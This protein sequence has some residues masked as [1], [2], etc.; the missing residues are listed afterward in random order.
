[1]QE[2]AKPLGIAVAIGSD[3]DVNKAREGARTLAEYVGFSR[4]E[5]VLIS[6]VA[7]ELARAV[8][9]LV[10]PGR[11]EMNVVREAGRAGVVLAAHFN[12]A[13]TSK[14]KLGRLNRLLRGM[15]KMDDVEIFHENT[16]RILTMKKWLHDRRRPDAQGLGTR[17]RDRRTPATQPAQVSVTDSV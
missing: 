11:I 2:Q 6:A 12:S 3:S 10:E 7:S 1:M 9:D 8:A 16:E 14:G 4:T 17:N 15:E 5:V 13:G